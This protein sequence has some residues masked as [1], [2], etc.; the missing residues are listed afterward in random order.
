MT[1]LSGP[2]SARYAA[3]LPGELKRVPLGAL[4][5][6]YHL[7]SGLTHLIAEPMPDLLNAM[8]ALAPGSA[9]TA[10]GLHALIADRFV[11]EGDAPDESHE[12][13]IGQR[14]AELAEL[15]LV[16]IVHPKA[17]PIAQQA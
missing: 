14:L 13:V 2:E 7:P 15:G 17:A 12:R 6:I 8:T 9:V 1:G 4:E 16:Q 5:A 3:L 11:I 10:L